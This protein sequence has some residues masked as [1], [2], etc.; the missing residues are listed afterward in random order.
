M[1]PTPPPS[2]LHPTFHLVQFSLHQLSRPFLSASNEN[3]TFS[4]IRSIKFRHKFVF[5]IGRTGCQASTK[6]AWFR[7]TSVRQPFRRK[8]IFNTYIQRRWLRWWLGPGNEDENEDYDKAGNGDGDSSSFPRL[9]PA[10][11]PNLNI[12]FL[13]A[14]ISSQ[15]SQLVWSLL[16]I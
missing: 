13:S 7:K 11:L 4:D 14:P 12:R 9:N 1:P 2:P 3:Q 15:F 5:K 8:G 10:P 16:Y 6:E